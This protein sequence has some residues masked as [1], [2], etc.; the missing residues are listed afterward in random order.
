VRS[1][2]LLAALSD[3]QKADAEFQREVASQVPAGLL[4]EIQELHQAAL[5]LQAVGAVP[6]GRG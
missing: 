5:E 4:A 6:T 1:L 3:Q 2:C